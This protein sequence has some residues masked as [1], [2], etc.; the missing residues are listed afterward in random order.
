MFRRANILDKR[1]DRNNESALRMTPAFFVFIQKSY[2]CINFSEK[3]L[4]LEKSFTNL[5]ILF[6]CLEEI[7][8]VIL[9]A[10]GF[11]PCFCSVLAEFL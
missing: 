5:K 3:Y 2:E 6:T 9:K 4:V 8:L 1:G 7:L 10:A 11:L